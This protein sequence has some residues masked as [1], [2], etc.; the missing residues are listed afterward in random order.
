ISYLLLFIL[1]S[2]AATYVYSHIFNINTSAD[3]LPLTEQK[4]MYLLILEQFIEMIMFYLATNF[5]IKNK[6]NLQ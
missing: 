2:V 6:L 4:T 5:I 1:I 3:S